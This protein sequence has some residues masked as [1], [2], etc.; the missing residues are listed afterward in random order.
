MPVRKWDE[1]V[2]YRMVC[3]ATDV[4]KRGATIE[5]TVCRNKLANVCHSAEQRD[6]QQCYQNNGVLLHNK[7]MRSNENKMS[8]GHWERG[9]TGAKRL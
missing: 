4:I 5:R 6:H 2:I 7:R 1:R 8:D 3:P 9:W